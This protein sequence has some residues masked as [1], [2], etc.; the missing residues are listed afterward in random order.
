MTAPGTG[1][2]GGT[3]GSGGAGGTGGIVD[4]GGT[5][6]TG[7]IVDTGGT[8]GTGG[9]VDTGGIGGIVGT[10]GS[11]GIGSVAFPALASKS[12]KAGRDRRFAVG[13]ICPPGGAA[14]AGQMTV[15]TVAKYRTSPSG[16]RKLLGLGSGRYALAAGSRGSV[17]LRLSAP[18]ARALAAG[19]VR[20][21]IILNPGGGKAPRRLAA[22]LTV[23]R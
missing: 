15:V 20:I 14:C 3:G 8:G 5:G 9:I 18:V 12:F 16:K 23:K 6:G 17:R 19:G 7:G 13:L 10:G 22:K 21:S 4:T 2:T 1:G 11:G